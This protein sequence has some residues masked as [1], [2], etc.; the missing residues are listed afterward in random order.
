MNEP[1]SWTSALSKAT[2]T[3]IF[4]AIGV[5]IAAHL[6]HQVLPMVLVLAGLVFVYR[7]A[8]GV[9]QRRGW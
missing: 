5:F 1:T 4:A 8:L 3:I 9:W 7:I 6:L 2:W